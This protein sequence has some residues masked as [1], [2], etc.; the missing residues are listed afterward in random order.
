MDYVTLKIPFSTD[1]AKDL[2][3]TAHLFRAAAQNVLVLAKHQSELPVGLVNWVNTFRGA[4]YG[5]IPNRRYADGAVALVMGIYIA[6]KALGID[7]KDA[8][9]GDWLMFQQGIFERLRTST[10]ALEQMD[11]DH[12]VFS[13]TTVGNGWGKTRITTTAS[14]HK[15]LLGAVIANDVEYMGRVVINEHAGARASGVVE[16]MIPLDFYN[17]L[18][19]EE[20]GGGKLVGGVS[21][22]ATAGEVDLA[23]IKGNNKIDHRKFV[24]S[25]AHDVGKVLEY[26]RDNNVGVLFMENP[27]IYGTLRWVQ[28][29]GNASSFTAKAEVIEE[30]A[31]EARQYGIRI[32]YV[33]PRVVMSNEL[34]K[35]A[36]QRL[37]RGRGGDGQVD[38]NT[39][40][41]YLIARRGLRASHT[42][43]RGIG[44]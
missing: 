22:T 2:L 35:R 41:A 16:L 42:G 3:T 19:A 30:L 5:V 31:L 28:P 4:A 27:V 18:I 8:E 43:G 14:K 20:Q 34:V 13:I 12:A 32:G 36:M 29:R 1:E 44:T 26:A 10:I 21:V 23:I 37:L 24:L 9:L 25:N 33:D 7:F 17:N 11:G 38:E 15:D 39:A 6:C 40:I